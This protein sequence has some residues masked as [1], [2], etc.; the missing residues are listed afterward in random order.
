MI[1][2][3]NTTIN[4]EATLEVGNVIYQIIH[5]T[6]NGGISNISCSIRKRNE[7]ESVEA[8]Y[9]EVG[10]IR[11]ENGQINS[12]ILDDEDVVAHYAQFIEIV[13]EIEK[14]E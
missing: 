4:K 6:V 7:Q 9:A 14:G 13:K 10:I 11:K 8:N 12:N 2:I 3:T 1:K 5:L